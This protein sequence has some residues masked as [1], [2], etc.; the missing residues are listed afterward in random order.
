[1][2]TKTIW[3]KCKF[4]WIATKRPN[5]PSGDVSWFSLSKSSGTANDPIGEFVNVTAKDNASI[6]QRSGFIDV[7]SGGDTVAVSVTQMAGSGQIMNLV[8]LGDNL[9]NVGNNLVN[10][11]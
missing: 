8:N 9:I 10:V 11:M 4:P 5:N 2:P 1:M 7:S 6:A 3:V